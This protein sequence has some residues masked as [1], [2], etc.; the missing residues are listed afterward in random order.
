M[1]QRL[2]THLNDFKVR[3]IFRK[4]KGIN[5][6]RGEQNKS[7]KFQDEKI[8]IINYKFCKDAYFLKPGRFEEMFGVEKTE[9]YVRALEK[10]GK[11]GYKIEKREFLGPH[12]LRI[13]T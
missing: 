6:G 4:L 11:K 7:I 2:E 13:V 5:I 3:K 1:M 8:G 12:L 9:L 10:L